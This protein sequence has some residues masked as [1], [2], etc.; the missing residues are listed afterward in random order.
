MRIPLKYGLII[1]L[2]G[3]AWVVITHL[4]ITDPTSPVHRFGAGIFL[5]LLEIAGIYLAI[6]S[7]RNSG[8][9]FSFK[10]GIKTGVATAFVYAISFCVFFVVAL[11]VVGSK[12]L[13][14][15]PGAQ[16]I[17]PWQAASGAFVGLFFGAMIFG[18]IYS[19]LISFF[20]VRHRQP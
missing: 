11:L 6:A 13:A 5:N 2:G 15:E 9:E 8:D 4:L 16:N 1:T 17:E 3:I 7:L 10:A 20:L 12:L 19:T 18:L 14:G